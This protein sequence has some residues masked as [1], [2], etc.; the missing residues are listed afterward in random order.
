MFNP[1]HTDPGHLGG[2]LGTSRN[3][4]RVV[5]WERD[6]HLRT[7]MGTEIKVQKRVPATEKLKTF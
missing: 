5:H 4:S 2:T 3:C 7:Q 1:F 6:K